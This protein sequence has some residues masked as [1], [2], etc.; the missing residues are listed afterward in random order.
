MHNH[1][2]FGLGGER[3]DSKHTKNG[4]YRHFPFIVVVTAAWWIGNN[5]DKPQA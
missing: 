3:H 2:E 4:A 1:P 5:G